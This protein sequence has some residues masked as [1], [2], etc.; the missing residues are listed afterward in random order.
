MCIFSSFVTKLCC[1]INRR[2][3][4][5]FIK[6][7]SLLKC[8]YIHMY[9]FSITD[10]LFGIGGSSV[11]YMFPTPDPPISDNLSVTRNLYLF[12]CQNV[13]YTRQNIKSLFPIPDISYTG[14][15][16]PYRTIFP[17]PDKMSN[18]GDPVWETCPV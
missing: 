2:V 9:M 6:E 1:F 5:Y 3:F 13:S 10:I 17:I 4:F 8:L 15:Y 11:E 16:F 7:N 12:V 14:Q 18:M